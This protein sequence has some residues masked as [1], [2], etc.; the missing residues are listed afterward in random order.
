[1]NWVIIRVRKGY[2]K[3]LSNVSTE[4]WAMR[5]E[6]AFYQTGIETGRLT[7]I[8]AL[9]DR[10]RLFFVRDRAFLQKT[11]PNWAISN[12]GFKF[13]FL[14]CFASK[15]RPTGRQKKNGPKS[16]VMLDVSPLAGRPAGNRGQVYSL[17]HARFILAILAR[18]PRWRMSYKDAV[19][20]GHPPPPIVY[21]VP[22][23]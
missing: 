1:M 22:L 19:Q 23:A 7:R 21:L 3:L 4:T 14:L 13:F 18:F 15:N 8:G 20:G 10:L 9:C 11:V 16:I 17:T 2:Q 12:S 5:P 6:W